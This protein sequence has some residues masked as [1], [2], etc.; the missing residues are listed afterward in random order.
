MKATQPK[1]AKEYFDRGYLT[2]IRAGDFDS[3]IADFS[4]AIRLQPN[5]AAAYHNRG[6]AY[7]EKGEGD[8]AL[9]DFSEAIKWQ[10][11]FVEA[12]ND[13]GLIYALDKGDLDSAMADFNM[14]IKLAP[15]EPLAYINRGNSYAKL[16]D[17]ANA[18]TDFTR[19][20]KLAPKDARPYNNRGN[21]HFEQ[22]DTGRA[23]ADFSKAIELDP[24]YI[25]SYI[26]RG[27][28]YIKLGKYDSA[29]V[30]FSEAL[31]IRPDHF[32]AYLSRGGCYGRK[33]DH[34][35]AI[36]DF[37]KALR[38]DP[39]SA[40]AHFKRGY[41]YA[42]K[43]DYD[44]AIADYTEVIRVAPD[45]HVAYNFRG[46]AYQS[47]GE[48]AKATAD[49]AK[50]KELEGTDGVKEK[51]A[52]KR[53][54][55]TQQTSVPTGNKIPKAKKRYPR[56]R[57]TP[58][59]NSVFVSDGDVIATGNR[60][61]QEYCCAT[62]WKNGQMLYPLAET[63]GRDNYLQAS[64]IFIFGNDVYVAG[65]VPAIIE[66]GGMPERFTDIATLWKNGEPQ[67]LGEGLAS[68]VFVADGDVYVAGTEK[69]VYEQ[70][71]KN[72]K[73]KTVIECTA[74]LWKNGELLCHLPSIGH[75]SEAKSVF[76]SDGD[77][78]VAGN[79]K[80]SAGKVKNH[81]RST[82][83]LWKN[84]ERQLLSDGE[85]S[86]R[87]YCAEA[88]SVFVSGDDVYVAGFERDENIT[89]IATLWKNGIAQRLSVA[90]DHAEARSVFVQQD[91]VYV[92]GMGIRLLGQKDF[93]GYAI[94]WKNGIPV[95]LTMDEKTRSEARSVFVSDDIVCVGGEEN[96]SPM[97][98]H[99]PKNQL[100]NDGKK[101]KEQELVKKVFD[102]LKS[103]MA[104]A[105]K[106]EHSLA[107]AEFSEAIRL[108]SKYPLTFFCR[109]GSYN[110]LGDHI[111]A[112]ADFSEAIRLDP[113]HPISY[114]GRGEAYKAIGETA[115]AK[116]DFAMIDK[117]QADE[118]ARTK[119][120]KS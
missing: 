1:T 100:M 33:N 17:Y 91:D 104:L 95:H 12:Y 93:G 105:Q 56:H 55:A 35:S 107:I 119:R 102:R 71:S 52:S 51:L 21:A 68:S 113:S 19:V 120:K 41:S 116:A 78:Y 48:T 96:G 84:G 87:R 110:K 39:N 31:N 2:V 85:L 76:V 117:L 101:A 88:L 111:S 64:S 59:I 45:I 10:A 108:D 27:D 63:D 53:K 44:S 4:E 5:F 114:M 98:W 49:F 42:E 37:T 81:V 72:G 54:I 106:N 30:D 60:R 86:G 32:G 14:A 7:L 46:M 8:A 83:I 38:L 50:A 57:F 90:E 40:N 66:E 115:K 13:R 70:I 75:S 103:G 22:G 61:E 28:S 25:Q 6:N 11:D 20:I 80:V 79:D 94:L 23:I 69:K 67:Y 47:K 43:G 77:I 82:A 3:A 24:N 18:I 99:I 58:S 74:V 62:V 16:G 26:N 15:K 65:F 34:D 97:I 9:A 29:I 109:G 92:A 36:A 118:K 89:P 112:I 73:S